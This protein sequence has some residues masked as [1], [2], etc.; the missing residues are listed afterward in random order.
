[1]SARSVE[2]S[3]R[4]SRVEDT[5]AWSP[6][7]QNAKKQSIPPFSQTQKIALC[8]MYLQY[9]NPVR[10]GGS[11]T[12]VYCCP[13]PTPI[14]GDSRRVAEMFVFSMSRQRFESRSRS[15]IVSGDT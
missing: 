13:S 7:N 6:R 2:A 8:V 3:W 1:M 15:L 9:V 11:V 4:T 12:K 10:A 5:T 14:R